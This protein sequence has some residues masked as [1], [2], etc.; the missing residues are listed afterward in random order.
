[1]G[2]VSKRENFFELLFVVKV[3][4]VGY[5]YFFIGVLCSINQ[6]SCDNEVCMLESFFDCEMIVLQYL[7]NGN[8]NKVIVQ[9][10]FFSEKIVSIYKL[11]IMLKFNVYFLVGLIDFVCC[12]EL[13]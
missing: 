11:C 6:Q 1:M 9:Q 8:I 13:I 12:Y 2:F 7:V 5:I 3:V 10:L 4:L